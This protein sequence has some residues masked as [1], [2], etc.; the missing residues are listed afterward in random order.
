MIEVRGKYT[1]AHIMIDEMD[2][3]TMSQVVEM[4]NNEVFVNPVR[5]MPDC[6]AGKGCVVGFTMEMGDKI[7]PNVIGVDISCGLISRNLGKNIFA[8]MTKEQLNKAIREVVPVGGNVRK[9]VSK[10]FDDGLFYSR[11]NRGISRLRQEYIKRQNFMDLKKKCESVD[12]IDMDMITLIYENCFE[13]CDYT[14][15]DDVISCLER[16]N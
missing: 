9:T 5:I 10:E 8:N 1:D 15:P 13:G 3:S 14:I 7:I 11:C 16:I 4:I 6:H 2:N 12:I